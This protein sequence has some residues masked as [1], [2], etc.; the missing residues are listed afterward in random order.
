M[1]SV[2]S[3]NRLPRH[4]SISREYVPDYSWL[5]YPLGAL[6]MVASAYVYA[7]CMAVS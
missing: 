1:S 3:G 7:L 2:T 5:A 6:V 4:N